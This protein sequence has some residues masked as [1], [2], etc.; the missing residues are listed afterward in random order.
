MLSNMER[1]RRPKLA[2]MRFRSPAMATT[3]L[4]MTT[5]RNA[6]MIMPTD[7]DIGR[8]VV[9]NIRST[10][11]EEIKTKC[12]ILQSVA[13]DTAVIAYTAMVGNTVRFRLQNLNGASRNQNQVRHSMPFSAKWCWRISRF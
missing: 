9:H 5:M 1:S 3:T 7:R 10:Y 6:K 13:L 2:F 11:S 8:Q 4:T 12:G